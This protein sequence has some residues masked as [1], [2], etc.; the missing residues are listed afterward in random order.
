MKLQVTISIFFFA[1]FSLVIG[2]EKSKTVDV[3]LVFREPFTLKLHVDAERFYEEKIKKIPYVHKGDVYLF[4][5]EAFGVIL[6]IEEGKVVRV[7]YEKDVKKADISFR[8]SQNIDKKS[9]EVMMMLVIKNHTKRRYY[10]DGLM[11]MP[12]KKGV[13]KTSIIPLEPELSNYESWP[14]PIVQLVLRSIRLS[15]KVE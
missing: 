12:G 11:T 1:C 10:F 7:T 3:G 5:G 15:E 8:F 13:Y 14:H 2:Q 9:K 6:K 4:S